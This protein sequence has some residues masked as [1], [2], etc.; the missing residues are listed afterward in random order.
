MSLDDDEDLKALRRAAS[1]RMWTLRLAGLGIVLGFVGMIAWNF[2]QPLRRRA[3]ARVTD[4]E[5]SAFR[6]RMADALQIVAAQEAA[7]A[8]Q[9]EPGAL[10]LAETTESECPLDLRPPT[11]TAIDSYLKH[12]SIDANYFGNVSFT[13]VKPGE[14]FGPCRACATAREAI[15]R[16][17]KQADA[18]E[19]ERHELGWYGRYDFGATGRDI[20][21]VADEWTE[22]KQISATFIPGHVSG[23]AWLYD[24]QAR[25]FV[26]MTELDVE[27]SPTVKGTPA[28]SARS[29]STSRCR[30][31]AP[32]R[33]PRCGSPKKARRSP[34]NDG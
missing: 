4:D 24:H 5:I 2:T 22:P 8:Q 17:L 27:S 9:A 30:S 33:G 28:C 31:S 19:L 11:T 12:G 32:S 20:F 29:S 21:V 25:R 7:W 26:C 34:R 3:R 16:G 14:A 6:A 18:G 13:R 1:R 23:R 15:A 10:E